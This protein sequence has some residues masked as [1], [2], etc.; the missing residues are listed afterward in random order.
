MA[1]DVQLADYPLMSP[2]SLRGEWRMEQE[3]QGPSQWSPQRVRGQHA[4]LSTSRVHLYSKRTPFSQGHRE[5]GMQTAISPKAELKL[6]KKSGH[7]PRSPR[8]SGPQKE[9]VIPGIVDFERIRRALRTPKPQTPG[10]YCFGRLSHHSFFSR[11]HPHPQ[12]VTHIQ[13]LTGKPVCVVRDFPAPLPESTVFSGCQMGIP[14]ISVPIGD[15]QSNRNPQLSSEAWKKELKEL[16]S[17]VAFLTKEDELKKKEDT[18]SL[19]W[20]CKSRR[21]QAPGL[22]GTD[23]GAA[24]LGIKKEQKEEPLR[25]QGAKYSAETGRLIPASTRAVGRRRSH[26]AQPS[27]SSSRHEGVQAF[28]LQDQELLVLE[29]LC[30]ILETDSLSAIQFWLLYA[31]PKEKDLALGLLQTAVAQLLPQ[32]LV[33]IPTEKLLNQLQEVHEPPQEKQEPPCS[34]SPKKTKIS[35]FTKSEKPEYIGEAQVLRMHSSQ[36]AEEKT[37]KPRAES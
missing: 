13:D 12:H 3:T 23:L 20:N 11:H 37:S 26:Q 1:T 34:Q 29:L 25:E 22:S 33:S 36:N 2:R 35:P 21:P 19:N 4:L 10:T 15:P 17:R 32:P 28:L 24:E 31:P 14:T 16:A 30:Q 8:D 7:K 27:Q 9:L 18:T 6:E 5:K